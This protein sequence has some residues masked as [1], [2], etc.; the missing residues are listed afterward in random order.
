MTRN[1]I[2][3]MNKKLPPIQAKNDVTHVLLMKLHERMNKKQILSVFD[4]TWSFQKSR[5]RNKKT[6]KKSKKRPI[7]APAIAVRLLII[8]IIIHVAYFNCIIQCVT[9]FKIHSVK[10]DFVK[11]IRK[12]EGLLI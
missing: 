8:I 7:I 5:R 11:V 2:T 6:I 3:R 10:T 12:V 1:L 4:V 9:E